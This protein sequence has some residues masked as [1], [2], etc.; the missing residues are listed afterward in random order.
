MTFALTPP[1][2]L[3]ELLEDWV[4][5]K[6]KFTFL[7][8]WVERIDSYEGRIASGIHAIL[9]WSLILIKWWLHSWTQLMKP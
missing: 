1:N 4:T 6:G 9:F 7:D 2:D 5:Q 3:S 8:I